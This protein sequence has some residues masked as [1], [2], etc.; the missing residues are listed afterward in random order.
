MAS[1]I[2][3][4]ILVIGGGLT[5]FIGAIWW[6]GRTLNRRWARAV[7]QVAEALGLAVEPVSGLNGGV[8]AQGQ[9]GRTTLRVERIGDAQGS[10]TFSRI[11]GSGSIPPDLELAPETV[12]AAV[13]KLL[14]GRDIEVGDAVFDRRMVVRGEEAVVRALL[15][16]ATRAAIL[17]APRVGFRVAAGKVTVEQPG[18]VNDPEK[19]LRLA[20]VGLRVAQALATPELDAR[21][22]QAALASDDADAALA[23]FHARMKR[24]ADARFAER[25]CA[26]PHA[27]VR[28]AAAR[29]R[30]IEA[31]SVL[32]GVAE[33]AAAPAAVRA[34]AL[35][36][37]MD[38]AR[39]EGVEVGQALLASP[40]MESWRPLVLDQLAE[41]GARPA[42]S[43]LSGLIP[44]ASPATRASI[45]A[46][47]AAADGD[48]QAPLLR[49]LDDPDAAVAL[50]AARALGERGTP[51]AVPALRGRATG[52]ELGRACEAAVEK[53]QSKIM[54]MAGGLSVGS[55]TSGALGLTAPEGD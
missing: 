7:E 40:E 54:E 49:L 9:I 50:A 19:L 10:G 14:R 11:I 47:L 46:H 31:V 2:A 35:A 32:R 21:L 52:G 22:E 3:T 4:V 17:E 36:V 37:L 5:A 8:A 24:G 55:A 34:E 16:D 6:L 25:A 38:R 28:L 48:V 12:T 39:A 42:A 20:R 26:S 18:S 29:R 27:A 15:D 30:G 51:A 33:D 53:I 1:D 44:S 45:A 43:A 23:A 13:G 41:A